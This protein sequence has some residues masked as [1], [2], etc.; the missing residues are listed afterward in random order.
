MAGKPLLAWS[1]DA[2]LEATGNPPY[3]V[4]GPDSDSTIEL[5]QDTPHIVQEERLGT[6][7]AV[8]QAKQTLHGKSKLILVCNADMPLLT[9]ATL[10]RLIDAQQG[11]S[12]PF[13]MLTFQ[14]DQ[15][16]GFG[17]V[18]HGEGG[19]AI[20]IVEEA[21]ASKDVLARSDLNAGVYCFDADWLWT[22]V[23]KL[24]LS[25]K[26][27]YYLTDLVA[28]AAEQDLSVQTIA[29]V[30]LDEVI[31]INDRV[32]LAEAEQAMR[33]RIN[34]GWMREGVTLQDPRTIYIESDVQIGSDTVIEANTHLRGKTRIG[35]NC[36][37]GA[38]S[39]IEE[40]YLGDRCQISASMV[41]GAT[42]EDDVT[43]GPFA[44]LRTGTHLSEGV[45]VGNF[46]E[47]K[48]STLGAGAKV[49]HF[50]YLGDATVGQDVNIG[51]GTITC[52]YDGSQKHPTVIEDEA[53][54]GSDTMLV[55][56]VRIGKGARTGA[57]AVV[58][59]DVP[60]RTLAAGIPARSIRKLEDND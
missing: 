18:L 33:K 12:G 54:I 13:T 46:G 31:G 45:H 3:V 51:A 44:R 1:I 6:G 34:E 58:T 55:A 2:C 50:S 49:G 17:R 9:P 60:N 43:V 10:K 15:S 28:C 16:R 41:N 5:I 4:V 36:R 38:N 30:D 59:K 48:N 47:I 27:E 32:H 22:W 35:S 29:T 11:H 25:P 21:L 37:I 23:D 8:Q 57:G 19:R 39:I 42:L 20:Q 56:P 52:N 26:G 40:S 7:H 53:F 24:P 14:S